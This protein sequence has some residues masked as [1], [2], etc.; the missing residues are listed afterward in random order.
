MK[1][2]QKKRPP[3]LANWLIS[4]L[5]N[6][7]LQEEFYG[8]LQ[9]I[10][11]D[12]ISNKGR[13]YANWMYWIDAFHLLIGFTSFKLYS[14]QNNP[15]IMFKHYLIVSGRNI[16]RNK[17]YSLINI[18]GL[19]VGMGVCLVI[20]QYIYFEHS[21]DKF[22]A[23]YQNIYRLIFDKTMNGVEQG[24]MPYMAYSVGVIAK[25][26]IP[27][28]K[29]CVRLYVTGEETVVTNP[30][31]NRPFIEQGFNMFFVDNSFLQVFDFPLK[32]GN[33]E[34]VLKDRFNVI[35]TEDIAKKYFGDEDP[36]GKILQ[37]SG[38]PTDGDFVVSGILENLPLN[39][40]LK[41][42]F[43]FSVENFIEE[44]WGGAV[45][46]NRHLPW[47]VTYFTLNDNANSE[48]VH[49]KLDQLIM[50]YK[51]EWNPDE[52]MAEKARLQ[53]ISDIHLKPESFAY[54]D[55]VS[56]KGNISDIQIY[57]MIALFILFIAWVNYINLSTAHSMQRAKEVG[58]RKSIGARRNQLI[59]QFLCESMAIN[60][61]ASIL[62]IGIAYLTLPILNQ[63]IRKELLFNLLEIPLFWLWFATIILFGAVL[64]GLYPAFVLS[65]YKPISMLSGKKPPLFKK[66]NLRKGLI[67]FQFL[68]SL[69]LIAGT[70]LVYQQIT[71]MKDQT[72]GMDLEKVLVLK[73]PKVIK[74][75][76]PDLAAF[77]EYIG[78]TFQT[79]REEV[80]RHH[81]IS[82]VTGSRHI[83][84]QINNTALLIQ[85]M[86][87]PASAGQY[88]KCFYVGQDFLKTYGLELIA[89]DV[90]KENPSNEKFIIINEE[91]VS[92]F[93]L[94]TPENAI[95]DKLIDIDD[96]DTLTVA[97]VVKNFHWQ[98]LRE[99]H[100]PYILM[101]DKLE[102]SNISFKINVSNL[103][104]SLLHIEKT[105]QLFFPNNPFE[106]FFMDD[107]YNQQ[108]QADLQFGRIF[109]TFTLLAIFIACVGLF[110]LVSYSTTLRIKEI[111]I[112]KVLGASTGNLMVLLSKEYLQLI[113]LAI[114]LAVPAIIYWG[115]SWLDNY[116]FKINLG[117]D[118]LFIPAFILFLISLLT[119]SYRTFS[120]AR[121]N[122]VD[123]LK[124]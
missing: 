114:F 3:A 46:R 108:Y 102:R 37:V 8:D 41:F 63:I 91:A 77:Q 116:A 115:S 76:F 9:E 124:K 79:F 50:K 53:T 118:L 23:N 29:E 70:Y 35:I 95:R 28:I 42:D 104:E 30:D 84:G 19:S 10:Y 58:V 5:I 97:G 17:V 99:P 40:H 38:G 86:G 89:G 51:G 75:D 68:V 93:N 65:S 24:S 11:E 105:Y 6:E 7:E 34:S 94:E 100:T 85:K 48:K 25:E 32:Q 45:K 4:K 78:P 13:N 119:V 80:A 117:I 111:G 112:R 55:F 27:E 61:L 74:G 54:P 16:L 22:H 83:P 101:F 12:R 36:L 90:F 120:T 109:F 1:E 33:K 72:L 66:F 110:A 39:N 56:E 52:N 18:L 49:Q 15:T 67:T 81:S 88:G 121:S 69:L 26:E 82:A 92:T 103:Q 57:A 98:S 122:P 59:F 31:R 107:S 71:F 20:C 21:Y 2:S 64:S 106:Y 87:E 47:F 123:A 14:N 113:F 73:G 43:L 96:N 60:V 62:A 44:G